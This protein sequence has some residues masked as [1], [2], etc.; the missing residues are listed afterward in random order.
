LTPGLLI[1]PSVFKV[2]ET[3]KS[4]VGSDFQHV[5]DMR[6]ALRL[7][8]NLEFKTRKL[9][10]GNLWRYISVTPVFATRLQY[11]GRIVEF[12]YNTTPDRIDDALNVIWLPYL[13]IFWLLE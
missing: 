13:P 11:R 4:S 7:Q 3:L 5:F 1:V 10:N 12:H 8:Q 2:Y 9:Q 6:S